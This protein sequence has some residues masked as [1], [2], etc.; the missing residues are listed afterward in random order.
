MCVEND[1]HST[2]EI[3]DF[4]SA[5]NLAFEDVKQEID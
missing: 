2:L 1:P 5:L 4:L 3:D